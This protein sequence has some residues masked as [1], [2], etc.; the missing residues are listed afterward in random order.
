MYERAAPLPSPVERRE[1]CAAARAVLACF[2]EAAAARRHP[3]EPLLEGG[4]FEQ[5]VHYPAPKG[6][7][8][9]SS[10]ARYYLHAHAG[11][12][13]GHLH[14]YL[15]PGALASVA[16]WNQPEV[17][18]WPTGAGAYSHLVGVTLDEHGLPTELF[19]LNRWV[20]Q[21]AFYRAADLCAALP[22]F[23]F[24]HAEPGYPT[25]DRAV[26]ALLR[27]FRPTVE[28]LLHARDAALEEHARRHPAGDPRESRELAVPSRIAIDLDARIAEVA[29]AS[30]RVRSRRARQ[31]GFAPLQAR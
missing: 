31:S 22:R 8:D 26:A 4:P 15:G 6:V 5:R 9:R 11:E 21:E 7:R 12:T 25:I 23:T 2:R 18:G 16:P 13:I 19:T 17:S 28:A 3:F 27:L 29:K 20:A 14:T 24:A 30:A 10:D 1:L